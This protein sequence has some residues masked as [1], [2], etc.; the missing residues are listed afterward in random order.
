MLDSI[1]FCICGFDLWKKRYPAQRSC[2]LLAEEGW[3]S[4]GWDF[5][6]NF[7][8]CITYITS[9]L[10]RSSSPLHYTTWSFPSFIQVFYYYKSHPSTDNLSQSG[11]RAR[12]K[13]HQTVNIIPPYHNQIKSNPHH[14]PLP[15]PAPSPSSTSTPELPPYQPPSPPPNSQSWPPTPQSWPPWPSTPTAKYPSPS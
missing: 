5:G 10:R 2:L 7:S 1:V 6:L 15:P 11:Y 3:R 14:P 8:D 4:R 13:Y 12:S 9:V